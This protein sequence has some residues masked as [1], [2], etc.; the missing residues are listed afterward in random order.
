MKSKSKAPKKQ[1]Y[2]HTD[3]CCA[4]LGRT[5]ETRHDK[6]GTVRLVKQC[7]ECASVWSVVESPKETECS[8]AR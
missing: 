3:D 5:V 1:P 8:G 6:D 4:V 2:R 7:A